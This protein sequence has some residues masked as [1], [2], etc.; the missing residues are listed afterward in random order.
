M[1]KRLPNSIDPSQFAAIFAP[2]D[3]AGHKGAFGS[4]AIVGGGP[5]M[6][7][8]AVL[9]ARSALKSGCGRVYVGLAQQDPAFSIDT[10]QPELMLRSISSLMGI[11]EQI[12]AWGVGCGLGDSA[13]SLQCLKTVFSHRG[14]APLVV[15]ADGL[16]AMARGDVSPTWGQASVVLTPHPAEA[17]RLLGTDTASVQANRTDAAQALAKQF[18]AWVLLKGQHTIVCTPTGQCQINTTGNV[19]LATA[20]SGDVLTGLL[21]SLL[22]QGF[23]PDIAVPAAVWLHGAAADALSA[24]LGGPIGLTA[25]ELI[26]SIR[27]LRNGVKSH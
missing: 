16:N 12:T 26:D 17:A 5:G 27:K 3:P 21:T 10:L 14:N 24:E 6:V 8:A 23:E 20:G 9:A 7:G 4:T 25:S 19:G 15:D 2:R 1:S 13:Y 18:N 11:S 22:A